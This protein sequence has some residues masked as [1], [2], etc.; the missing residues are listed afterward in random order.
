M[1]QLFVIEACFQWQYGGFYCEAT[2]SNWQFFKE[3]LD[4]DHS[5]DTFSFLSLQ[6]LGVVFAICLFRSIGY[7]KI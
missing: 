7:E 6:I 5:F 4:I 2:K 3:K 1:T